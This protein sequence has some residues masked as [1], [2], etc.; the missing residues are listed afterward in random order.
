MSGT[1]E[2]GQPSERQQ[3]LW[4]FDRMRYEIPEAE[5]V[6]A[7]VEA[8]RRG[9]VEYANALTR[10]EM[11]RAAETRNA[12]GRLARAVASAARLAIGSTGVYTSSSVLRPFDDA[13]LDEMSAAASNFLVAASDL[14]SSASAVVAALAD[15]SVPIDRA[16]VAAVAAQRGS[17]GGPSSDTFVS[18]KAT[19]SHAFAR[20]LNSSAGLPVYVGL[21]PWDMRGD[22]D[23][24]PHVPEQYPGLPRR[25]AAICPMQGMV[26]GSTAALAALADDGSLWALV[27]DDRLG[28]A[29]L[30]DLPAAKGFEDLDAARAPAV[31]PTAPQMRPN[32]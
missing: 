14:R 24:S 15:E 21:Q 28:W 17:W 27:A 32:A 10:S 8:L 3:L 30:P 2:S 4:R 31:V 9:H 13:A 11:S 12:M 26:A 25:V 6:N 22:D 1:T 20:Y 23:P 29:R 5:A 16:A 19:F 18:A 7:A